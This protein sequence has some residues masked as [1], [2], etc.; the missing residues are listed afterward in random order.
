MLKAC[1][2]LSYL[3]EGRKVHCEILKVGNPDSFVLTGFVDMYAKCGEVDCS[4]EVFDEITD[5]N[6]VSWTSMIAGYVQN[7]CTDEG[8]ILFNQMRVEARRI[9]STRNNIEESY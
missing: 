2:E 6:V 8:L 9:R 1:S 4:R 5:K 7:N 3:H